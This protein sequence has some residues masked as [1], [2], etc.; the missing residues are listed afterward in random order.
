MIRDLLAWL[1]FIVGAF[2]CAI[3]WFVLGRFS[4]LA[5]LGLVLWAVWLVLLGAHR[6]SFWVGDDVAPNE[7]DNFDAVDRHHEVTR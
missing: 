4:G 3:D 5:I 2:F 7:L 1:A 6:A